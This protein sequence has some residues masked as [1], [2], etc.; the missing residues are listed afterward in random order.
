MFDEVKK[1]LVGLVKAAESALPGSSGKEKKAWCVDKAITLVEMGDNFIPLIGAWM[2]LPVVDGFER[3]IVG[4]GVEWAWT[5]L[6]LPEDA[7]PLEASAPAF[8]G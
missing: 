6:S 1:L 3:Y 4:L 5:G 2:D 7:Q 8:A